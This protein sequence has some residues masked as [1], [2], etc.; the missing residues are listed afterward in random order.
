[1]KQTELELQ[2]KPTT[3]NEKSDHRS[4]QPVF[5]QSKNDLEH[6]VKVL[7]ELVKSDNKQNLLVHMRKSLSDET[8]LEPDRIEW[9]IKTIQT[10][11]FLLE[12]AKL[13]QSDFI[14]QSTVA[15]SSNSWLKIMLKHIPSKPRYALT[16]TTILIQLNQDLWFEKGKG[17]KM[18]CNNCDCTIHI[19]LKEPT[20]VTTIAD[21]LDIS[22][23]KVSLISCYQDQYTLTIEARSI[24][25]AYTLSSMLLETD[26]ISH[27]GNVFSSIHFL[28]KNNSSSQLSVARAEVSQGTWKPDE[29]AA[30]TCELDYDAALKL[31]E[32]P[33]ANNP[34]KD[35]S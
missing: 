12:K 16:S 21:A 29:S 28:D 22:H 11:K 7:L 1:M 24:N 14:P 17:T 13:K 32:N 20:A 9:V 8:E 19:S 18:Q 10:D 34:F 4:T 31:F 30:K 33:P 23:D 15:F 27:S 25:H 26:R 3:N 5:A 6:G 35:Q 2:S